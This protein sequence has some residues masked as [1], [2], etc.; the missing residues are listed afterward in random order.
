MVMLKDGQEAGIMKL[1]F[2]NGTLNQP[3]INLISHGQNGIVIN[4]KIMLLLRKAS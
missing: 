3:E 1:S 4:N 2:K